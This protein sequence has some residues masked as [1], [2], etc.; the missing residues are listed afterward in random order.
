M[1]LILAGAT[2]LVGAEVLRQAI[3]DPDIT[4]IRLILRRPIPLQNDKLETVVVEDFDQLGSFPRPNPNCVAI[5]S[6]GAT[7]KKAGSQ[8]V[9]RKADYDS[10]LNFA[11]YCA[12][13]QSFVVV[14][15]MGANAGAHFFYSRVKGETEQALERLGLQRLVIFQPGL[16]VGDR[17]EQRFGE[18]VG[19][20]AFHLIERVLPNAINRNWAT[21]VSTLATA[22]L[23]AAKETARGVHR[24][25]ASKI[26]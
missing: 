2:G 24:I 8:E 3:L 12:D 25:S 14:S 9:F 5:C 18:Q 7:I 13:V 19:I 11:K 26:I 10:V 6:L 1:E 4:K 17:I 21:K 20:Q 23:R 15:A 16:L 22:L